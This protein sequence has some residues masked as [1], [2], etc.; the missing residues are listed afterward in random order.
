LFRRET[1]LMDD[2]HLPGTTRAT[3]LIRDDHKKIHGLFRQFE[4]VDLRAHEIKRALIAEIFM[5]LEI[6]AQIEEE[7]FYRTLLNVLDEGRRGSIN[8]ARNEH[9]QVKGLISELKQLPVDQESFNPK[10]GELIQ[11]VEEHIEKEEREILPLMEGTDSPI[12]SEEETRNLS[13]RMQVRK[14]ELMEKPE[15]EVARSRPAQYPN[16]GEQKRKGHA[17]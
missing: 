6:H 2:L 14:L 7:M 8:E 11:S 1:Q 4:V 15:Y 3:Q 12:L 13:Y 9:E 16:G 17:A 10:F 5:E